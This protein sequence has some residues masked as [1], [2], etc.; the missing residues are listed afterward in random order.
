M[1]ALQEEGGANW[2][3][4]QGEIEDLLQSKQPLPPQLQQLMEAR[5]AIATLTH[6]LRQ[7]PSLAKAAI[8][9]VSCQEAPHGVFGCFCKYCTLALHFVLEALLPTIWTHKGRDSPALP[10]G[11]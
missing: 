11:P 9:F 10:A 3:Y 7:H 8:P 2:S 6:P 1:S 4:S 5:S